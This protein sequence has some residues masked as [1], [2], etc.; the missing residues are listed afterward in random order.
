[1]RGLSLSRAGRG[2]NRRGYVKSGV[3]EK[4]GGLRLV[5]FSRS[6]LSLAWKPPY[7]LSSGLSVT[8]GSPSTAPIF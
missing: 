5:V 7:S 3:V 8:A 4:G 1:M 2:W 6:S